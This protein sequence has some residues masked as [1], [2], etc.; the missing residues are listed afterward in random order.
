MKKL[1]LVFIILFLFMIPTICF[2]TSTYPDGKP[3]FNKYWMKYTTVSGNIYYR[4]TLIEPIVRK[5]NYS[6]TWYDVIIY[7]YD[8]STNTWIHETTATSSTFDVSKCYGIFTNFNIKFN[9]DTVFFFSNVSA[10]ATPTPAGTTTPTPTDDS[11]GGDNDWSWGFDGIINALSSLAQNI[12]NAVAN[13]F[14]PS[15]NFLNN[16]VTGL[17]NNFNDKFGGVFTLITEINNNIN[18]LE[19]E[20]FQ[21]IKIKFP[22]NSYLPVSGEFYLLDPGPINE[23]AEKTKFWISG[24]MIFLSS[25]FAIRRVVSLLRGGVN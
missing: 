6:F 13:L 24:L 14:V 10:P 7:K 11:S 8:N 20:E 1:F 25:L 2:A 22:E 21:G 5:S 23:Y 15:D 17:T 12:A 18:Q 19:S 9:D 16:Q 3:D 4:E